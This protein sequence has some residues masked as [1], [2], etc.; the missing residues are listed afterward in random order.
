MIAIYQD[1]LLTDRVD[2]RNEWRRGRYGSR[3]T[4]LDCG[5]TAQVN[6]NQI[7]SDTIE[8]QY[9]NLSHAPSNLQEADVAKRRDAHRAAVPVHRVSLTAR[10]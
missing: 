10:A 7:D 2:C 4:S 5:L 6:V 8:L 1:D 3:L 9:I